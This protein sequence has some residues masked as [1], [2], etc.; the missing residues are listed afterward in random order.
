LLV[1]LSIKFRILFIVLLF[2]TGCNATPP[3]EPIG[4]PVGSPTAGSQEFTLA[5]ARY[6]HS[7]ANDGDKIYVFG[8][9]TNDGFSGDIEIIDPQ[10]KKSQLLKNKLIPRRYFSAVWDGKESVYIIGGMSLESRRPYLQSAVEVFNTRTH[11][12]TQAPSHTRATRMNTAVY[13]DDKIY[14]FG[15]TTAGAGLR[16]GLKHVAWV[17]VYDTKTQQWTE[18]DDMPLAF[19]TEAVVYKNAI[20]LAG[21]FNGRKQF[22]TFYEFTPA[23]SQWRELTPLPVETS[24]HSMTIINNNLYTFGNYDEMEQTLRYNFDTGHWSNANLPLAPRRHT[25]STTLGN[26]IYVIGGTE[27]RS[28]LFID[29]VQ[30]FTF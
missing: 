25:A 23:S 15:G 30:I 2:I 17:S 1:H 7:V 13:S 14:V 26:D 5:E 29:S 24:A 11:E 22:D 27:G 16:K 18:S 28:G 12:V 20:Y 4:N 3:S 9:T 6:G 8:G 10:T 21:G 19:A